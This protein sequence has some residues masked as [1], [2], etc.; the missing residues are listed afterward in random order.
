MSIVNE[1]K[2]Y[3]ALASSSRLKILKLLHKK[4]LSVEEIAESVNLQSISVRHHLQLLEDAGFVES[5]EER[6]G[7]VGRPKVYYEIAEEPNVVG[8]PRRRYLILS[9][10]IIERLRSLIGSKKAKGLFKSVGNVMGESAVKEIESKHDIREW[11]CETFR[12]FFIARYLEEAGAEPEILKVE[13]NRVT[14]RTHNCLFLELAVKMPE[15]MC[16]VFH[17]A[18]DEGVISAMGGGAKITRT[19]CKGHGDAYCEHV[20]TWHVLSE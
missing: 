2:A 10:Y 6:T 15:I 17:D 1:K 9:T 14:Y 11:S 19:T 20:C 12:D 16:D 8:Y 4:P 5:H 18:F 3:E 7:T 13:K